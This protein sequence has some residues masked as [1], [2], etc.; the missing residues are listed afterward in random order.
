MPQTIRFALPFRA[1]ALGLS[2]TLATAGMTPAQTPAQAPAQ[3]SKTQNPPP[4][5]GF[6]DDRTAAQRDLEA[7]FDASLKAEN[8]RTWMQRLAAHPHPV[9]SPWGKENAEFMAGLLRSWGYD[10]ALEEFHVL[11]PTPKTR[12]LELLAPTRFTASLTEPPIEGDSTSGQTAEQLPVYNAYSIDGDVTGDLVFVNYGVPAD[13]EELER[14]GV[15][16]RGKIVIARYGGSWRGIKPKLA[17]EKGAIGCII[18]SDPR[19]D[20]YTQGDPYPKGG[21]RPDHGAQRGSV[22]DMPLFPGDPLTPFVGATRDAKRV[23]I[24]QAQTLTKIPVLPI[25]RADAL[26]LLQAL[27]GPMA[28]AGWRGALP[29]PYH[30]GPGPAKVRLQLEFDWK[31]VPAYDVIA[32]LEGSQYPE[33]WVIRGNHH[34]GWV[35]GAADPISGM[36]AVLEEARAIG[37]LVKSGWRPKRT[38]VFA[39]W[40]AEEPGLL[41]SVEWAETHADL[42]RERA[43]AYINSDSNSRGFLEI[44]GSHI[45]EALANEIARDVPD[46]QTGVSVSERLRAALT[47]DSSPEDRR[48]IRETGTFRIYPLGSGSD[49]TPFL[50]HLGIA[51]INVGYGGEDQYGQYHSVYDSFDHYVRF[52]DPDFSYGVAL[53][54]TGGRFVLRLAEADVLPYEMTRFSSTVGRYV[55]E[56]TRLADE[57]RTQTEERNRRLTDRAYELTDDPKGGFVPPKRLDPVPFLNFAPLQNAAAALDQSAKA[58]QKALAVRTTGGRPLSAAETK[59]LNAI[60]LTTERALTRKEGLPRRPWFRHQIYAPGFYTGYGVKTLAGVREALEQRNWKEAEEQVEVLA[61]VLAGYTQVVDRATAVLE[62][63]GKGR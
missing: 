2:L 58:Y 53:A 20:G 6:G 47:L 38:I 26:P 23:D 51:S 9:G 11:F 56:V 59:E 62:G 42:L 5:L 27:G 60:L 40:D 35:N 29:I 3:T 10:V 63:A 21:W 31:I 49:Y 15:D 22:A 50:Q 37:E 45:L 16:V 43:V 57:L 7:R 32:K 46:P 41:G 33:Q 39:G 28:P 12:R 44:G 61:G 14:R 18:Y 4:L 55:E 36:V 13:Y 25:S 19:E 52:M 24:S 54:K 17:A 1:L 48:V 8:L 30:L 34:D